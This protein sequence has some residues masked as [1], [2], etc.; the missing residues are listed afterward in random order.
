M[1]AQHGVTT[2]AEGVELAQV[3]VEGLERD[4]RVEQMDQQIEHA[5]KR[6]AVSVFE[7][8]RERRECQREPLRV[9]GFRMRDHV[10]AEPL[11][12]AVGCAGAAE[13][14][15]EA[16]LGSMSGARVAVKPLYPASAVARDDELDTGVAALECAVE[17]HAKPAFGARAAMRGVQHGGQLGGQRRPELLLV[18]DLSADPGVMRAL[19]R[20]AQVAE[21]TPHQGKPLHIDN[22]VAPNRH[23]QHRVTYSLVA[24]QRETAF[25]ATQYDDAPTAAAAHP[26]EIA[27]QLV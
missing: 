19:H 15:I 17:V 25:A 11:V 23:P 27:H 1:R 4:Q 20:L 8:F 26:R 24:P 21:S 12:D 3:P 13:G 10:D 22:N 2:L 18:D 6:A 7:D 9:M 5:V 16:D 14:H